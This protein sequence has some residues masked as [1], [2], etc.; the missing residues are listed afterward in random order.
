MYRRNPRF[1]AADLVWARAVKYWGLRNV[2]LYTLRTYNRRYRKLGI[3]VFRKNHRKMSRPWFRTLADPR[4]RQLNK[5]F[6]DHR[7]ISN[8]HEQT[9]YNF[10]HD[11]YLSI[12]LFEL[13]VVILSLVVQ[14]V[15]IFMAYI[16]FD[17]PGLDGNH[18]THRVLLQIASILR[19]LR[20]SR[21]LARVEK[22]RSLANA[23]LRAFTGVLWILARIVNTTAVP[24]F[25]LQNTQ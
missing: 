13:W 2:F 25:I 6:N 12:I 14:T 19:I 23:L 4:N 9:P 16:N 20:V 10:L 1:E 15:Y 21:I 7:N 22:L 17:Q 11:E 18:P 5:E 8:V 3:E 24:V